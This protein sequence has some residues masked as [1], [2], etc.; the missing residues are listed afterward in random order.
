MVNGAGLPQPVALWNEFDL[1]G[2]RYAIREDQSLGDDISSR[3]FPG[4]L[5]DVGNEPLT[6]I[7]A[8]R[9]G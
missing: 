5:A 7:L 1:P 8:A 3:A 6:L 2:K 4:K 9:F